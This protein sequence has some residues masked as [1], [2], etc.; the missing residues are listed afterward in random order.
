MKLDLL[1]KDKTLKDLNII[2]VIMN[3]F[4]KFIKHFIKNDEKK[5]DIKEDPLVVMSEQLITNIKHNRF[6]LLDCIIWEKTLQT[7]TKEDLYKVINYIDPFGNTM[8]HYI[9]SG[10][11]CINIELLN[12]LLG[13]NCFDFNIKDMNGDTV[14]H[15]YSRV[16]ITSCEPLLELYVKIDNFFIK[17]NKGEIPFYNIIDLYFEYDSYKRHMLLKYFDENRLYSIYDIDNL[18]NYID[19]SNSI[20]YKIG[21]IFKE[22]LIHKRKE[23]ATG[24]FIILDNILPTNV[25]NL[26]MEY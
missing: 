24:V 17:N 19:N 4:N 1:N 14:L 23:I 16:M 13:T 26:I 2:K 12:V 6:D 22:I 5:D 9:Y 10:T 8:M 18:C 25:A 3:Y 7:L 11:H 20:E 21:K 15:K